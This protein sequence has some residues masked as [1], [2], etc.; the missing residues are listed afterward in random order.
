[1][2]LAMCGRRSVFS[3]EA[4]LSKSKAKKKAVEKQNA[5]TRI[6][7]VGPDQVI[8]VKIT[9]HPNPSASTP[10]PAC[11]CV[12]FRSTSGHYCFPIANN[13]AAGAWIETL[14]NAMLSS[15]TIEITPVTTAPIP[16]LS[17]P[18]QYVF[19]DNYMVVSGLGGVLMLETDPDNG[20]PFTVISGLS[21]P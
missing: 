6:A 19:A 12:Y 15:T 21:S 1:M 7:A 9:P 20:G 4:A 3:K 11:L 18:Q 13:P 2:P 5:E 14:V 17:N 10:P 8:W 16:P